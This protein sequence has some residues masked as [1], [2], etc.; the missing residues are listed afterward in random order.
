MKKMLVVV[1]SLNV[2]SGVTNHVMNYYNV[3][4]NDMKIDF[5]VLSND[6][7]TYREQIQKDGNK[8]YN[9]SRYNIEKI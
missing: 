7:K 3:L 6:D 4:K 5:A 8:V 9:F 2:R 1:P